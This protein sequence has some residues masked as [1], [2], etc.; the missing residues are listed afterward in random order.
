MT[1]LTKFLTILCTPPSRSGRLLLSGRETAKKN[2]KQIWE[3]C[4]TTNRGWIQVNLTMAGTLSL[5]RTSLLRLVEVEDR[6]IV[7][8]IAGPTILCLATLESGSLAIDR[9]KM[10]NSNTLGFLSM[11]R[12]K[13]TR[14]TSSSWNSTIIRVVGLRDPMCHFVLSSSTSEYEVHLYLELVEG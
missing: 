3:V 9:P 2:E 6:G 1:F 4:K 11:L 8:V 10:K 14:N 7:N 12:M 5:L 13:M